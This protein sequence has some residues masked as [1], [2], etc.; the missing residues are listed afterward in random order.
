MGDPGTDCAFWNISGKSV[1]RSYAVKGRGGEARIPAIGR[2]Q[3]V[4]G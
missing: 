2:T 1:K 3:A 4:V